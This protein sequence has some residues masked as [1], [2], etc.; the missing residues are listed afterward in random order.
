MT[1]AS[2]ESNKVSI[3]VKLKWMG[4]ILLP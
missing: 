3:E 2:L 1:R 4:F